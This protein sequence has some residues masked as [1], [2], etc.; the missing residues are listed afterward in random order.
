M[1]WIMKHFIANLCLE[2]T[3]KCNNSKL[4]YRIFGIYGR[5]KFSMFFWRKF[6]KLYPNGFDDFR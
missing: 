1:G 4:L 6:R 3:R 5:D 2:L